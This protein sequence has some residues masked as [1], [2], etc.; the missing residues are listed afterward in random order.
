[1]KLRGFNVALAFSLAPSLVGLAGCETQDP[2]DGSLTYGEF[3]LTSDDQ[4]DDG[5]DETAD[6]EKL[7]DM[8]DDPG[9]FEEEAN[10]TPEESDDPALIPPEK[11]EG[12]ARTF[13]VTWG[14]PV[15]NP[16]GPLTVWDGAISSEVAYLKVLRKVRFEDGD[17]LF[18]DDDPHAVSFL[19]KTKPH[20]DGLLIRVSVPSYDAA[21]A[22][23]LSFVTENFQASINL[24]E[25]MDG[26]TREIKADGLG[27]Y[28]TLVAIPEAACPAGAAH[29]RWR[30]ID[31]RG[32][33]F[34][35]RMIDREGNHKGYLVG[36]W[37]QVG[38]K[39]RFKGLVL[40]L[41]KQVVGRLRGAWHPVNQDGGLL[42]GHW[43]SKDG[44]AR[45]LLRGAYRISDTPGQ[46]S[47]GALFVE[48][49][50]ASTANCEADM[51]LPESSAAC[52]CT[53]PPAT[54]GEPETDAMANQDCVCEP[55][56]PT[57]C[58]DGGPVEPMAPPPAE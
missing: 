6:T 17:Q 40:N 15:H 5:L 32:G 9:A 21:V 24:A 10:P 56:D 45:G 7:M 35:G 36:L 44:E 38:G 3:A 51:S 19:T 27:N 34:G 33:V 57:T 4:S 22:G 39:R 29:F 20:H 46:G 47:A 53:A 13:L 52:T 23:E 50:P 43:R 49:C 16:D 42:R 30:R 48:R 1:M 41:D 12:R 18:R 8:V 54:P 2:G 28:V 37:G 11:P 14:Q 25:L 26:F 58:I 55:A 31:E